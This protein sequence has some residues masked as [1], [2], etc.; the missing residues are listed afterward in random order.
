MEKNKDF[1][2]GFNFIEGNGE[3]NGNTLK[4]GISSYHDQ[5]ISG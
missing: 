2:D 3:W 5:K 4:N 1:K